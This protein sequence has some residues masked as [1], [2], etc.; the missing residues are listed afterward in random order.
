LLGVPNVGGQAPAVPV[1]VPAV[2][3]SLA[4]DYPCSGNACKCPSDT[5]CMVVSDEGKTSC[6]VPGD[7][8]AGQAC[9]CQWGHVCSKATNECVKLCQTAAP[10]DDCGSDR[11][12]ATPVLPA[13][14]GV[15]VGYV[16]PDAD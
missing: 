4:E 5:A 15:C 13:G 10:G 11:C 12:Q 7:G 6:V 1:C 8:R 9:P 16:P 14:W 3:C 2:E